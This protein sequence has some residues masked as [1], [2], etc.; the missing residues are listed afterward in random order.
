MNM[1]TTSPKPKRATSKTRTGPVVAHGKPKQV[2]LKAE[3]R[4]LRVLALMEQ[5]LPANRACADVGIS[6]RTFL[7]WVERSDSNRQGYARARGKLLD[8]MAEEIHSIA[9][10][11]I[12]GETTTTRADGSIEV[13]RGD[14]LEHR[15]L[16]IDARKWL[17]SKLMPHKYGDRQQIDHNV[18]ADTAAILMAARKRS[19]K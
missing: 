17:L 11:P 5:G 8:L 18:T 19:G 4:A 7:D 12:E 14:M 2:Q 15:K 9:N 10:T 13:K 1:R 6:W 3:P 16:Q